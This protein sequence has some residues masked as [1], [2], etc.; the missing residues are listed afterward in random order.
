MSWQVYR[1]MRDAYFRDKQAQALS[2]VERSVMDLATSG[3]GL[4]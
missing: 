3:L 1:T 4:P 2:P